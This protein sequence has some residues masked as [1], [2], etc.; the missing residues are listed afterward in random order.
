MQCVEAFLGYFFPLLE[1]SNSPKA[2]N[3]AQSVRRIRHTRKRTPLGFRVSMVRTAHPTKVTGPDPSPDRVRG[4]D[5]SKNWIPAFAGMT[6][7]E[8]GRF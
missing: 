4:Q 5:D 2:K 7:V 1:R 3:F 8:A 6:K